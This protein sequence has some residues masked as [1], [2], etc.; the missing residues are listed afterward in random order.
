MSE[1][2]MRAEIGVLGL[3][4]MR[5]AWSCWRCDGEVIF[6]EGR[7]EGVRVG[8]FSKVWSWREE[9]GR[10][11]I[12]YLYIVEFFSLILMDVY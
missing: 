10:E 2:G 5:W 6:E 11:S 7:G 9:R 4:L 1:N 8:G 12:V 3:V